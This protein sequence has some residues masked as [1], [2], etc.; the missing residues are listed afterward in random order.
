M[1]FMIRDFQNKIVELFNKTPLPMEVKRLVL[2][3]ILSQV[4]E[5]ADKLVIEQQIEQQKGAA[6]ASL[7]EDPVD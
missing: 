7:S 3:N 1:D 2:L 4:K 6:D 5:E